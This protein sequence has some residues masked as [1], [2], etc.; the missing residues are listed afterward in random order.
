MGSFDVEL[1]SSVLA[2]TAAIA[3]ASALVVAP[4]TAFVAAITWAAACAIAPTTTS[5]APTTATAA[6]LLG[7][8]GGD[9]FG[10]LLGT[11]DLEPLDQVGFCTLRRGDRDQ[12]GAVQGELCFGSQDVADCASCRQQGST[13][14]ALWL[15]R[16]GGT[17]RKRAVAAI[18]GDLNIDACRHDDC[19]SYPTA[20]H[21]KRFFVKQQ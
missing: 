10:V 4:G 9:S 21:L 14:V 13:K 2:A 6:T 16:S 7:E 1:V 8:L 20:R 18:A 3:V 15:F 12:L 11:N 19:Q 17:P 5:V